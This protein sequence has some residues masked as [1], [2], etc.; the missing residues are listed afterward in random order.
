[1]MLVLLAAKH[2]SE[3]WIVLWD[4]LNSLLFSSIV[5]VLQIVFE[6]NQL[7]VGIWEVYMMGIPFQS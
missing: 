6:T 1:M 7:L 5:F 3:L 2:M 4:Q